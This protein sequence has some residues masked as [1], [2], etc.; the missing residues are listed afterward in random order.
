MKKI[1]FLMH[2]MLITSTIMF[3]QITKTKIASA[4]EKVSNYTYDS[5]INFLGKK[6]IGY[7]G[8]ELY[9]KPKSIGL[10]SYGYE[11]FFN[12]M[13]DDYDIDRKNIYK[14]C[15]S[16]NSKYGEV[17]DKYFIVLDVIK[18][19]K[20]EETEV[21]YGNKYFLKLQE[22]DSKEICYYKYDS[23]FDMNFPFIVTGFFTKQKQSMAGKKLV[24]RG[25]NWWNWEK[26]I[27]DMNTG[28]IVSEFEPG[29]IWT[30]VDLTIEEKYYNLCIVLENSKH[31]RIPLSFDL[32]DNNHYV[33]DLNLANYYKHKFGNDNWQLIIAGKVKIGMTNDM[34]EVAFGKPQ[35]VNQT[36]TAGKSS[37]QW[38][39]K[40]NYLYFTNGILT[41]MQ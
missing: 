23:D 7:I 14:C 5:S 9:L 41:A 15:D 13:D 19:P 12:N 33:F 28:N 27:T 26:T 22:K 39:Y 38:V 29:A 36:I 6:V 40:D 30:V 10:R 31:E 16:Y 37:E 18:H 11:N 21:L 24:V 4:N 32:I 25:I 17:A 2:L 3:S 8:Q 20:A 1:L 35:K 34:C